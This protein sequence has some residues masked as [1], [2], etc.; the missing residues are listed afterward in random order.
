M[1]IYETFPDFDDFDENDQEDLLAVYQS[2]KIINF[3]ELEKGIFGKGEDTFAG[4]RTNKTFQEISNEITMSTPFGKNS[5]F[6]KPTVEDYDPLS[7]DF[8][9]DGIDYELLANHLKNCKSPYLLDR[10][11]P[12][13]FV[14]V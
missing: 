5:V 14:N 13:L 9:T 8:Y 4:I 3:Q 10:I 11:K 7:E 1:N 2:G 12:S 6:Y